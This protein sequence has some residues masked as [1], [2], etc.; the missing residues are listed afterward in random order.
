MDAE[1]DGDQAEEHHEEFTLLDQVGPAGGVDDGSNFLHGFMNRLI[2]DLLE[3]K[4]AENQGSGNDQCT[5]KQ[6]IPGG[7]V[8][9]ADMKRS[10]MEI[11]NRQ[12]GFAGV[13]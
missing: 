1:H 9:S 4:Q 3:K 6:K 13:R 8:K 12:I 7:N 5:V 10:R 11:R 2:L